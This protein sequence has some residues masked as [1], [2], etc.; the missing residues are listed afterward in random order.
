MNKNFPTP[1]DYESAEMGIRRLDVIPSNRG[2][3]SGS[4]IDALVSEVRTLTRT[5]R[6]TLGD[7]RI[8]SGPNV[9]V[10]QRL[11]E[12]SAATRRAAP[13][14]LVW[15]TWPEDGRLGVLPSG[16]TTIDLPEQTV[17]NNAYSEKFEVPDE[18]SKVAQ[19]VVIYVDITVR[20]R[21]DPGAGYFL[22][23]PGV[24]E[25][26]SRRIRKLIFD[27]PIVPYNLLIAIGS[28][29][30]AADIR[31]HAIAQPR[32]HTSTL[33]KS[34]AAGTA[35]PFVPVTFTVRSSSQTLDQDEFGSSLLLT[36]GFAQKMFVVT[37]SGP[38]AINARLRG[39]VFAT[40]YVQDPDSTEVTIPS[41]ESAVIESGLPYGTALFET[42][43][44]EAE[45]TGAEAEI[46]VDYMGIAGTAR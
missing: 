42:R 39:A 16:L 24:I 2:N 6:D 13:E 29:P 9:D 15:A 20:M 23:G 26:N 43:V 14:V 37:N 27:S 10:L 22:I 11:T 34:A 32:L 41:G 17:R 40:N 28:G 21:I 12:I 36:Y 35:D 30:I 5:L 8:P 3:G 46:T 18:V 19:S 45:T 1:S 38:G 25:I 44:D 4:E 31:S 33:E 7:L